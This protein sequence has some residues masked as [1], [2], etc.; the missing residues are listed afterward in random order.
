MAIGYCTQA[1]GLQTSEASVC[2]FLC[3]LTVV[4]DPGVKYSFGVGGV[5]GK[6]T[7]TAVRGI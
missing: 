3:S 7:P 4:S 2:A 5:G 6:I 1:I